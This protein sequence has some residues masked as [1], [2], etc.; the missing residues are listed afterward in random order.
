MKEIKEVTVV[1]GQRGG[2][3]ISGVFIDEIKIKALREITEEFHE[4]GYVFLKRSNSM[5]SSSRSS[6]FTSNNRE[7]AM[8]QFVPLSPRF[9][10]LFLLTLLLFLGIHPY[11]TGEIRHNIEACI[12]SLE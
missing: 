6:G 5:N 7:V 4:K 9:Q 3:Q 1:I 11:A 2:G 8:I 12:A 10:G